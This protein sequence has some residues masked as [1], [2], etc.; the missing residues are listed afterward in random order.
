MKE[1]MGKMGFD[2]AWEAGHAAK[3]LIDLVRGEDAKKLAIT[4][5]QKKKMDEATMEFADMAVADYQEEQGVENTETKTENK[6]E[7]D[8]EKLRQGLAEE[9]KINLEKYMDEI[10]DFSLMT[11]SKKANGDFATN[12]KLRPVEYSPNYD[13]SYEFNGLP[14]YRNYSQERQSGYVVDKV[15][16]LY[17]FVASL[18]RALHT[19]DRP[20]NS[21]TVTLKGEKG[22]QLS[23]ELVNSIKKLMDTI[24]PYDNDKRCGNETLNED[25]KNILKEGLPVLEA[26]EDISK[27]FPANGMISVQ[28]VIKEYKE[29]LSEYEQKG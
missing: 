1:G 9:V 25:L 15:S 22:K 16:N 10:K 8:I 14:R 27:K 20:G 18:G 2:K 21:I 29:M 3:P 12:D 26:F 5:E 13:S 19:P 4:E 17:T 24:I 11:T 23:A 7:T 28:G 6:K